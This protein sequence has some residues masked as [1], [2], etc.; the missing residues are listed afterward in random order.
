MSILTVTGG[1][2]FVVFIGLL[3]VAALIPD[4]DWM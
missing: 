1:I 3:I 4:E 2:M